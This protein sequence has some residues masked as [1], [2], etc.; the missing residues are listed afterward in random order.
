MAIQK[1]TGT[2]DPAIRASW[3]RCE[4]D[5][6]LR[7]RTARP[8][9]RLQSAEVAP[10]LERL[11][12]L[13]GGR[14]GF[15]RHLADVAANTGR[16]LVVTDADGVLVRLE[17]DPKDKATI[18]REGIAVGSCWR[19]QLAGTNGVSMALDQRDVFTVRGDQHYFSALKPFVCTGM[20]LFDADDKVIG[21]IGLASLDRGLHDTDLF[22]QQLLQET[23]RRLQHHLFEQIFQE[24]L[25]IE[26]A[27]T[28]LDS[29]YPTKELIAVDGNGAIKGATHEAAEKLGLSSR[30]ALLGEALEG[31]VEMDL[32]QIEHANQ[33]IF[34][35]RL[36]VQF[37][38][39]P[40]RNDV[41]L[42]RAA[43]AAGKGQDRSR[44]APTLRELSHGDPNMTNLLERAQL[45]FR[46]RNPMLI[47]GETGSGKS[48]LIKALRNAEGLS[49][50][51][52]V[53]INCGLIEGDDQEAPKLDRLLA[54]ARMHDAMADVLTEKILIVLEDVDAAPPAFQ[55]SLRGFL[56]DIEAGDDLVKPGRVA[57][58]LRIIATCRIDLK[59][60]VE[61]GEFREDLFF[62]LSGA[63]LTLTPLRQRRGLE[64][65]ATSLAT[66]M[67]GAPVELSDDA[68]DLIGRY[69]W[70]GNVREMI[71]L[72]RQALLEG[73]GKKISA[74][75][76]RLDESEIADCPLALTQ[77][78]AVA[79][80][81]E[82]AVLLDALQ[83]SGWNVSKAARSL[84]VGRATIHR[85][86]NAFGVARPKTGA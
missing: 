16:A 79:G 53:V 38:H 85:K 9:L 23:S 17:T 69:A 76:L 44:L 74:Y 86:M 49:S 29:F 52:V 19:E 34:D 68:V 75:Q 50:S 7:R 63:R 81:D 4:A 33:S 58:N 45:H 39:R 27:S 72:L 30:S 18:E 43:G 3:L 84:G 36:G 51:E 73:D 56:G 15:I 8:I 13:V 5:Y 20:P 65:L 46:H 6:Q 24:E 35:A 59:A 10:R 2:A 42:L 32:R 71:N 83:A 64:R 47:E 70:P 21:S 55:A 41:R 66:R 48:S 14:R 40:A 60:A 31:L 28:S 62:L 12:D 82:K 25:I 11:V 37:S 80:Y 26:I 67:A 1:R 77:Q 57:P 22:S 78:K 54:S 61:C